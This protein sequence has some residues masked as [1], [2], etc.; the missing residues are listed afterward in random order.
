MLNVLVWTKGLNVSK[1]MRFQTKTIKF[2]KLYRLLKLSPTDDV[3]KKI[4]KLIF[5]DFLI[6]KILRALLLKHIIYLAYTRD[7]NNFAQ[8]ITAVRTSMLNI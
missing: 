2:L 6:P 7:M 1:C 5:T 3:N 8:F 4:T